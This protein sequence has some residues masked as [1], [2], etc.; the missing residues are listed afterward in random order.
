ML[1][2]TSSYAGVFQ[3]VTA[4]LSLSPFLFS[5]RTAERESSA[6]IIIPLFSKTPV[7]KNKTLLRHCEPHAWRF[8]IERYGTAVK[9][10]PQ[11]AKGEI[12][13]PAATFI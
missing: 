1:Y 10:S 2:T 13:S 9:Q 7:T 4:Y 6:T 12:A 5:L 3:I 11:L 8:I